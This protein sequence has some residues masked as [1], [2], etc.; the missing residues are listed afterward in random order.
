MK[1]ISRVLWCLRSW[2]IDPAGPTPS[3]LH[4][5][6]PGTTATGTRARHPRHPRTRWVRESRG[7]F[8]P[9]GQDSRGLLGFAGALGTMVTN[10]RFSCPQ[11][12]SPKKG[13]FYP[14]G[15]ENQGEN[16]GKVHPV[17]QNQGEKCTQW[18]RIRGS[19][20]GGDKN[21]FSRARDPLFYTILKKHL[22]S[23]FPKMHP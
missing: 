8:D 6:L 1:K 23:G 19:A 15:S 12:K 10:P 13:G 17:G 3:P 9:L 22:F 2:T 5:R 20:G 4:P 14:T 11:P 18:V 16:W 21:P 7:F